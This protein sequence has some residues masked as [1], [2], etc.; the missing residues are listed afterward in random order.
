[1]NV[2]M[3]LALMGSALI[4]W[5]VMNVFVKKDMNLVSNMAYV[6]VS[7]FFC[8]SAVDQFSIIFLFSKMLMS[9]HNR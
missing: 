7:Y 8:C 5:V 9:V 4:H 1:M 2:L 6:L 3:Y